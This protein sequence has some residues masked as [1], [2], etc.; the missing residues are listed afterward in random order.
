MDYLDTQ[1]HLKELEATL[2]A[3]EEAARVSVKEAIEAISAE[4]IQEIREKIRL[5]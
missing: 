1:D 2:Q 5:L 3:L 4:Q